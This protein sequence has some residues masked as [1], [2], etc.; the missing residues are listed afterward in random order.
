MTKASKIYPNTKQMLLFQMAIFIF[1]S[2]L[3]MNVL[4]VWSGEHKSDANVSAAV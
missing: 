4:V 3:T 1:V 2:T